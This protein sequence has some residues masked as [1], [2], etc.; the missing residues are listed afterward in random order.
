MGKILEIKE[1]VPTITTLPDGL[2]NGTWGGY[3]IEVHYK[4]KTYELTT[5]DGVKGMG[6]KVVVTI[7]NGVA[8][9]DE[10]KN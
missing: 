8:T 2:Y 5:E 7:K 6:I 3:V 1:K 4:G 10:L 9:F